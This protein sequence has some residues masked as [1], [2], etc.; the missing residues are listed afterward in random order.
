MVKWS[1]EKL[2]AMLYH[3]SLDDK[4]KFTMGKVFSKFI[5]EFI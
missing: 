1:K 2:G 4:E 3:S 5:P